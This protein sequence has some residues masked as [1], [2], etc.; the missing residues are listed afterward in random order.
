LYKSIA[1]LENVNECGAATS[2]S[3]L[4]ENA[5]PPMSTLENGPR[6]D[7]RSAGAPIPP[8][9]FSSRKRRKWAF[10][11]SVA[12][13]V[14]GCGTLGAIYAV[15]VGP[16]RAER[17]FRHAVSYFSTLARSF[18]E[19]AQ[20][21]AN[22]NPNVVGTAPPWDGYVRVTPDDAKTMGLLVATVR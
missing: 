18:T 17:E 9:N 22:E 20:P 10:A 12:F 19:T 3:H 5:S 2:Y 11:K 14:V 21:T 4:R 7:S 13:C 6:I 8:A 15:A 16:A 1:I